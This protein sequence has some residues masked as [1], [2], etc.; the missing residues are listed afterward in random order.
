MRAGQTA[1][2]NPLASRAIPKSSCECSHPRTG[3]WPCL[4]H[5]NVRP[6]LHTVHALVR[7][8]CLVHTN[9]VHPLPPASCAHYPCPLHLGPPT[10]SSGHV[11]SSSLSTHCRLRHESS[12]RRVHTHAMAS[13]HCRVHIGAM[14]SAY[15][16]SFRPTCPGRPVRTSPIAVLCAPIQLRRPVSTSPIAVL[17]API[18]LRRPVCTVLCATIRSRLPTVAYTPALGTWRLPAVACTRALSLHQAL[19]TTAYLLSRARKAL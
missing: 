16:H 6:A 12:Y 15:G 7:A 8:P 4:V 13:T 10:L 9:S 19:P 5:T 1:H 2:P 14:A 3:A 17:Y 18:Q 11:H